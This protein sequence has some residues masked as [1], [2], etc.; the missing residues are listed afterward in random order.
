[1]NRVSKMKITALVSGTERR[2]QRP[3]QVPCSTHKRYRWPF[4]AP[5]SGTVRVPGAGTLLRSSSSPGKQEP[6]SCVS[7]IDSPIGRGTRLEALA[8]SA[9]Q[10]GLIWFLGPGVE[11]VALQTRQTRAATN[12]GGRYAAVFPKTT[13]VRNRHGPGLVSRAQERGVMMRDP[14]SD[15]TPNP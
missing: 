7:A 9:D 6:W 5:T 11:P 10:E 8:T 15:A 1:M 4:L 12:Q 13:R 2:L 14:P 3:V